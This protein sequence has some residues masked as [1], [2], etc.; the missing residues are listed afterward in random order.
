MHNVLFVKVRAASYYL[1]QTFN[2]KLLWEA[3]MNF[4]QLMKTATI[5]E[6]EDTVVV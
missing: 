5:A 3:L 6:F 4:Q 1:G 2:S